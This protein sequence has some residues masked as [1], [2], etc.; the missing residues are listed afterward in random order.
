[1]RWPGIRARQ[2]CEKELILQE[3]YYFCGRPEPV[4]PLFCQLMVR[5]M[6]STVLCLHRRLLKTSPN[7]DLIVVSS[8]ANVF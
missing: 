6:P 3:F 7:L 1:M 8:F 5:G 2:D 4:L